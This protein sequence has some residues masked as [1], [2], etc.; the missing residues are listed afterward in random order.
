MQTDQEREEIKLKGATLLHD[1]Q[2]AEVATRERF[3][4]IEGTW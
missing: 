4:K 3:L 1:F 2:V